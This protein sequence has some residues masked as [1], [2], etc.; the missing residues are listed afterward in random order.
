[1]RYF[2]VRDISEYNDEDEF[3]NRYDIVFHDEVNRIVRYS[4]D[5]YDT[6]NEAEKAA[7]RLELAKPQPE[8]YEWESTGVTI[9]K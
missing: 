4:P 3:E 1:M 2:Q 6:H 5:V 9:D 7:R 8:H